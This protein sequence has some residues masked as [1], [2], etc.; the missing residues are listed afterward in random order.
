VEGTLS[1]ELIHWDHIRSA[2][3]LVDVN[4]NDNKNTVGYAGSSFSK[5]VAGHGCLSPDEVYI[6]LIVS[7]PDFKKSF[8][9][10]TPTSNIDIVPAI[11][12]LYHIAVPATMDGRV[13]YELF[14]GKPQQKALTEK[15][16]TI[17]TSVKM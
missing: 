5:G 8:E 9:L 13:L 12:Y 10:N 7:G 11:L 2:D 16:E 4:W 1:Y 14:S 3:I 6:P 15:K 17:T